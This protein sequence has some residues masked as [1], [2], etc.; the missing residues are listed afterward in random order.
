LRKT[1]AVRVQEKPSGF[2]VS[3][4][5]RWG[6]VQAVARD[7]VP[8]ARKMRADLMG[9]A[10]ADTHFQQREALEA[11]EHLVFGDGG[12]AFGAATEFRDALEERGLRY[13]VGIAPQA[14]VWIEPP[15]IQVPRYSGRGAPPKKWDYGGQ[16]PSSVKDVALQAKGWKKVRWREGS[17]GWLESRFLALRVQPSHGF[18]QGDPPHK[19]IRLLVE[20]PEAEKEPV[21]YFFCDLPASYT[22]RRLVRIAKCRWK[23]EQ[24]YRQLKEELGLDR[25]E[26][27]S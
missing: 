8:D 12:A 14:G 18:V 21:E 2:R 26:G 25:Y 10:G 24:D 19:E 7:R 3:R 13:A 9:A 16:R 1:N 4:D 22:L 27:R 6:A 11:I 5:A 17:K 15:Q 23:S 20:W